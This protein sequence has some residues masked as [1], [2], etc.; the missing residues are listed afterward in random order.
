MRISTSSHW[1]GMASSLFLIVVTIFGYFGASFLG[2][3][4]VTTLHQFPVIGSQFGSTSPRSQ[5][6]GYSAGL[7]IG[8][9]GLLYGAQ[10]V[11]QSAEQ[12]MASVW[13]VP[14]SE[15]PSFL[16]RL[17]RSLGGLA[18]I[19]GSFLL[20]AFMASVAAGQS[21]HLTVRARLIAGLVVM[22]IALFVASFRVLTPTVRGIRKFLPGA[23]VASVGFTALTTV[24]SA[25]VQ[26]Q[27]RHSSSTYGAFG[28]IIGVVAFLL[29]LAKL[30]I[31]STELNTVLARRLASLTDQIASD[32]GRQAGSH[33]AD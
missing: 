7:L 33:G 3:G 6:H 4:V 27:L 30:A 2:N 14:E 18:L 8:L 9:V 29:L 10:G 16:P 31:Y 11:T 12:V 26:F 32:R 20:N 22:D 25:L 15:R 24:G 28:A 23:V 21:Q 5:I 1:A 13:S 19:G 17:V